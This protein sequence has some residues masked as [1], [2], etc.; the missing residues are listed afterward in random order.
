MK[1]TKKL[2]LEVANLLTL[3]ALAPDQD[4]DWQAVRDFTD[5]VTHSEL[6]CFQLDLLTDWVHKIADERLGWRRRRRP[7]GELLV[8]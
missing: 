2:A 7:A 6:D 8:L 3:S 4:L 5:S 1:P